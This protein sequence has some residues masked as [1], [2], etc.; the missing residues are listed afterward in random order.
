MSA[1]APIS[2]TVGPGAPRRARDIVALQ[3]AVLRWYDANGRSLAFRG[4]RDPYAVLV[5]E[6]MAQQTQVARVVPA[7]TGFIAAFPTVASLAAASPAAVLR[8]WAG[9]GYNRRALNL[10]AAARAIVDRHGGR[11]PGA[12]ADLQA[13]PGIGPYTAR[14][15]GAI[16]FGLPVAA[17]D[18]NVRRVVGRLMAQQPDPSPADLQSMADRLVPRTRAADWAH[19]VMDV[20]ATVCRVREPRCGDCPATPWCQYARVP[21]EPVARVSRRAAGAGSGFPGTRRWLRGRIVARLRGADSPSWLR[22]DR[23]I[24]EHPVE[25]VAIALAALAR[26]GLLERHPADASL[27]RLPQGRAAGR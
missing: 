5:S 25:A 16:A 24:G 13:L 26:D 14:A 7:W 20:G 3:A 23:P 18:T 4:T 17:V 21:H 22:F 19:A 6:V 2:P 15:V 12:L 27:A 1:S 8:A 10:R 11:V 9:L